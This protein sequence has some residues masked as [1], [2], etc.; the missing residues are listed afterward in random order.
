MS[1]SLLGLAF[2]AGIATVLSPCILPIL[3]ILVGRSLR[4]HRLGP[5]AL[6]TGLALVFALTGSLLS[7]TGPL[8]GPLSSG[9]R[10]FALL[11]LLLLGL[12]SAFPAFG[13]RL[14]GWAS[15]LRLP[16]WFERLTENDSL[17]AE[18][19][20]G[21]QLGLVWVP[22]AGPILGSIL[23]LSITGQ[24]ASAFLA[25]LVYAL[26]AAVPMLAFAYGSK[27]LVERLQL[28]KGH[29]EKLQRIGGT[30]IA[31]AA[32]AI[33]LGWDNQLQLW[34]AP[35]FPGSPL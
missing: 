9:L 31:L 35:L 34:L 15:S 32:I 5:L 4:S 22:C 7:L 3:P 26:G 27:G 6:V 21:S 17:S 10:L 1:P 20:V 19:L 25:L 18:F 11:A 30:C 2:V 14:F 24:A 33:L 29:T 16:G 12:A 28:L 8:L 23:A 13:H